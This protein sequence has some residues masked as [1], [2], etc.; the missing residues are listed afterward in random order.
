MTKKIE[1]K[2]KGAELVDLDQLVPFQGNLK[3]GAPGAKAIAHG[4][5]EVRK[6]GDRESKKKPKKG[7]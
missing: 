3:E 7:A 4:A 6:H 5:Q 2:C 1:I